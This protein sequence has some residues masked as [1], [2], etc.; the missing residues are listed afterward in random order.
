MCVCVCV[1]SLIFPYSNELDKKT[2]GSPQ[3][4]KRA[5]SVKQPLCKATEFALKLLA[6]LSAILFALA[7]A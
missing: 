2:Y 6:H 7:S 4:C 5:V 3:R 1:F